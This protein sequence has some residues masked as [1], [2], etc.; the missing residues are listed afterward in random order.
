MDLTVTPKRGGRSFGGEN[1]DLA[2]FGPI[3]EGEGSFMDNI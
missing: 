3:R 2:K 1:V